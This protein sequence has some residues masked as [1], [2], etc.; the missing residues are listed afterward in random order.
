MWE[1]RSVS[2]EAGHGEGGLVQGLLLPGLYPA[3]LRR[4]GAYSWCPG[5]NVWQDEEEAPTERGLVTDTAMSLLFSSKPS[6]SAA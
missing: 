2:D 5:G 4:K 1:G 3:F 6:H